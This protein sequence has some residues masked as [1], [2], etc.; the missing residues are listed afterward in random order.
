VSLNRRERRIINREREAWNALGKKLDDLE[1]EFEER[2]LTSELSYWE[3][4]EHFK[5]KW[6]LITY[7]YNRKAKELKAD[8]DHFENKYK[9]LETPKS[10]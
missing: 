10:A 6:K 1:N 5:F 4:Y 9:P 7:N 3:L 8:V 2:L